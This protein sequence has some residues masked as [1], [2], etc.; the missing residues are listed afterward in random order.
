MV[1]LEVMKMETPIVA[2]QD[3]VIAS[4]N[5]TAGQMVEAGETLATM[6]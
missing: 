1:T 3:G 4:I 2:P 6:N 5:V